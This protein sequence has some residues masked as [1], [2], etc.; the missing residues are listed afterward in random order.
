MAAALA[1]SGTEFNKAWDV[2]SELSEIVGTGPFIMESYSPGQRVTY[3]RN[4]RYWK[5][6]RKGN[7]LPYLT[8]YVRLV[9]PTQDAQRLK[10]FAK[11][12]DLYEARPREFADLKRNET[13]GNYSVQDGPEAL[14]SE[15]LVF[16]QNA[17]GVSPP[18]LMWFQDV[19]VRRALNY[20]IN[21]GVIVQ[22]AYGGR[23]TPAWGPLSP[24]DKP[25][26][27]P[28]LPQSP[29][30]LN[31]AQQLLAEAGYRK[32][33]NGDLRDA[34]GSIVEFVLST[35]L[36]HPEREIIGSILR[37][38]FASLGVKVTFAPEGLNTLVG[39]LV[40]TYRWDAMIISLA[41]T[42]EPA[43]GSRNVW[44]S[45]GALHV[46]H[47]EQEK[48]ATEWEAEVDQVFDH[49]S[50]E[51]DPGR[52][53]QLYYRWQ[54]IIAQ[55]MPM[56]FFAYPKTQ[57]AVRNTLGNVKPGLGGAIGE[58]VTLYSKAPYR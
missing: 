57:I 5:V 10:F 47:P 34:Q 28:N 33:P 32:D 26:V 27:Y 21:R 53:T 6:D 30:D 39:K 17:A 29:Y 2:S 16:N 23:A 51:V 12:T 50:R 14:G 9:V 45:S 46:W 13:A 38:D 19:Q 54:E 3:L 7:R 20:A 24:A 43:V 48:P 22:Q 49:I 18:K 11:E 1:K 4:G 15:F 41:G 25:Y 31:R 58:L 36:V 37:Q 55:Q 35:S 42:L 44:M 56:M 8:R 40:V 52:R